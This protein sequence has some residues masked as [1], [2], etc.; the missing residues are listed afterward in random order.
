MRKYIE[1]LQNENQTRD[2]AGSTLSISDKVR[3]NMEAK[4]NEPTE[5]GSCP[6]VS[7]ASSPSSSPSPFLGAAGVKKIPKVKSTLKTRNKS[8]ATKTAKKGFFSGWFG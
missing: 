8:T 6:S 1:D 3:A 7:G 4:K 5:E 2:P